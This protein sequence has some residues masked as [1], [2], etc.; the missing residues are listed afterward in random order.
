M[1]G[2]RPWTIEPLQPEA[3]GSGVLRLWAAVARFDGSVPARDEGALAACLAHPGADQGKDWRVAVAGNGA[4]VGV[5]EV[6][7][8][9]T[10][11]TEF[12]I[13]VNPAWRRQG[14]GRALAD[15]LPLGKRLLTS[16]RASVESTTA[17]LQALGFAERWR[18]LR[19]RRPAEPMEPPQ[20]PVWASLDAE[21]APQADRF[22]RA[23]QVA[24]AEGEI[25][26]EADVHTL[27]ASPACQVLYL[28]TP[29]GDQGV[30]CVH[31]LAQAR[32]NEQDGDGNAHVGVLAHVG[33][34][35][36]CRGRG[37]SRPFVRAGLG[38]L[39]AAGYR[40]LEVIADGR[41]EAAAELYRKE[42][43]L[44]VDEEIRWIRRDDEG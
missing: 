9:G 17:F 18:D 5:L 27:L 28:Q 43:F 40:E 8:V 37:L 44:L 15:T 42:G 12:S 31:A 3:H 30:L 38:L 13:A 32:R 10:K 26:D 1:A 14:V 4:V 20:F 23:A 2:R 39:A 19:L 24:L 7:F 41:R 16:S 33:L 29:Q 6:R 11:R 25:D 36:D 21:A 22:W 35:K 34:A